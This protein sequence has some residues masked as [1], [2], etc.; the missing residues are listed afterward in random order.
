MS[1]SV[2][3]CLSLSVSLSLWPSSFIYISESII[4]HL[5]RRNSKLPKN[6]RENDMI[7]CWIL[8]ILI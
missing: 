1:L 7:Y 8:D 6:C 3:L 5:Q 4:F 2:S